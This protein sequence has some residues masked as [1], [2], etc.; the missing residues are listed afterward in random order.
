MPF[1]RNAWYCAGFGADLKPEALNPI[2]ILGEA[3]VLFRRADGSPAAL[4]DRCPHRFA[5]LSRGLERA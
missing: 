1:L 3:V 2:T 4:A 5:P